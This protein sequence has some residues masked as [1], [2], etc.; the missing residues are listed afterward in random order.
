MGE[1]R[2]AAALAALSEG[3]Y[4]RPLLIVNTRRPSKAE[5]DAGRVSS[6]P[7]RWDTFII[8]SIIMNYHTTP[9]PLL[10]SAASFGSEGSV[11][12]PILFD[13]GLGNRLQEFKS[14]VTGPRIAQQ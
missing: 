12:S 2:G 6:R 4:R 1:G 13:L 9:S 14:D 8:I 10:S 7:P 11:T 3:V 5:V